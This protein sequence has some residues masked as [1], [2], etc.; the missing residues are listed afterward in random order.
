VDPNKV[1]FSENGELTTPLPRDPDIRAA[2]LAQ[3]RANS[4]ARGHG[5]AP[6]AQFAPMQDAHKPAPMFVS[7]YDMQ[8]EA[9]QPSGAQGHAE[10]G[11]YNLKLPDDFHPTRE[12]LEAGDVVWVKDEAPMEP[13]ASYIAQDFG[14]VDQTVS[15]P[16]DPDIAVGPNHVVV[17]V[18]Q[19]F[20]FF[21]KCGNNLFQ[22]FFSTFAGNTTDRFFDPKVIYDRYDD[23]WIM[24]ICKRNVSQETSH[25]AIWISDDDNP[26][27]NWCGWYINY[28]PNGWADYQD[29][30]ADADAVIITVNMFTWGGGLQHA[31]I[32][33][34]DKADM[35]AC[36]FLDSAFW[37]NIT[38]PKDGSLAACIRASDPMSW[39][40]D[41]WLI[42]SKF[43]GGDFLTLWSI[44]GGWAS[45]TLL[46]WNLDVSTYDDPPPLVQPN[47]TYV[48]CGD[49]R[50]LNAAFYNGYLWAGHAR[51]HPWI[52][53]DYSGFV[54]FQVSTTSKT[55]ISEDGYAAN[56]H[57]IAY[58]SVEL[59]KTGNGVVCYSHGGPTRFIG[60]YYRNLAH[61]GP[62]SSA[63]MLAFGWTN[64]EDLYNAGTPS[65]PFRW[66][67][68]LGSD[69]DPYDDKTLWIYGQYTSMDSY[70]PWDTHVGA[71][72]IHGPGLL[73]VTPVDGYDFAG[74]EGGPFTPPSAT[75][76]ISNTGGTA[77]PW[78]LTGIPT[79][80]TPSVTT[81]KLQAGASQILTVTVNSNAD[82]LDPGLYSGWLDL[83]SCYTGAG[84]SARRA[85]DLWVGGDGS[86]PGS[87]VEM[88]PDRIVDYIN[89]SSPAAERGMFVTAI[90]DFELCA[91]RWEANINVP[92]SLYA[93][94]Y[95]AD[96]NTRGALLAQGSLTVVQAGKVV[97]NVP[98][99]Y[100]LEA[101]QEYEITV[102]FGNGSAWDYWDANNNAMPYDAD[103][104]I[105]VRSGSLAGSAANALMN[106]SLVGSEP[107]CELVDDLGP[108]SPPDY[109]AGD[110]YQQRG[111]Y[112]T[113]DRTISLCSFGQ[114]AYLLPPQTVTARV[115]EASGT[116]RGALIAE[117]TLD[118]TSSGDMWHD[119]P[120]NVTLLEGHDYN[121]TF[122]FGASDTWDWWDDRPLMPHNAGP[123][124]NIDG[125]FFGQ[126]DNFALPHYRVG[127]TEPAGG[128]PF[129]LALPNG[130]WP[131]HHTTSQDDFDYG[132]YVTSLI[133][134]EVYSVGWFADVPAGA[135]VGARVYQATGTARGA[136]ISEGTVLSPG[137]GLR[138]HDVPVAA[139]LSADGEYDIEIDI[140]QVDEW[141]TWNDFSLP[142]DAY[143]VMRVRDGEQGG[144]A[145]NFWLVHM[146]Y[147]GCNETA[148]AVADGGPQRVPMFLA[149]PAPNPISSTAKIRF[150]LEEDA[151]VTMAVYD[152]KG[153][154][155]ATILDG[156]R[157]PMGEHTV[158][159][160][161]HELPSGVYFIK[162]STRMKSMSR[163]VV[164][165]H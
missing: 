104:V 129:D 49:A 55:I 14:G 39:S 71:T 118:V 144:S 3:A 31:H 61:G 115:Y 131:G 10:P 60:T 77:V 42:T 76:T 136:L 156:E 92:Q 137:S 87:I 150:G 18:N 36:N 128:A 107:V 81:G 52:S 74:F 110:N 90:K 72:S 20:A 122:Q 48:D 79:W 114:R 21:D 139:S 65:D 19:R 37:Y 121:I 155:V 165:T 23:R 149:T 69:L 113:A 162:L 86:C 85:T 5:R 57:Y 125:E 32:R 82:T 51:R 47:G 96:G 142:F 130:P 62:L 101:C 134:Q 17:V 123:F 70:P 112:V 152:V 59:D 119:V 132:A 91:I 7:T 68:Y 43:A 40:S 1:H 66:G 159:M 98:I 94:I 50:L 111:I 100:T 22:S 164:V 16:P 80:L 97:H 34:I 106:L 78:D 143:G 158:E 99:D 12:E 95:A 84:P 63:S 54:V 138:W 145:T 117:G 30:G 108:I 89:A 73:S 53:V 35:L 153:R 26:V 44:R 160:S 45:P 83:E 103:G 146:R 154:R 33:I 88:H 4:L 27:G 163:K 127:Y 105:R 147:N 140:G 75:F 151:A 13:M 2:A 116:T 56:G 135:V 28:G 102:G 38:N 9:E 29:V 25:V 161:A 58:P 24:T 148:T 64:Y 46:S 157:R 133:D 120:I 124:R 93:N 141:H 6:D 67:D 8:S 41:Y 109:S 126:A 15:S 11:T